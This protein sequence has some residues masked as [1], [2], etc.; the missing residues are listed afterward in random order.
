MNI[1]CSLMQLNDVRE[2]VDIVAVHPIVGPR[3][4]SAISDLR[5]AWSRL[6]VG[7]GYAEVTRRN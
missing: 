2:R 7:E 3:Y 1:R 5:A 6:L 4:R